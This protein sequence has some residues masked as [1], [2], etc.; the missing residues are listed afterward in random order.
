M[1]KFK[2]VVYVKKGEFGWVSTYIQDDQFIE[3]R[4][5]NKADMPKKEGYYEVI[6]D[7]GFR[8]YVGPTG[9][10]SIYG[11]G[12]CKFNK[13]DLVDETLADRIE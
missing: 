6:S 13:V 12:E 11:N 2:E 4:P 1:F 5:Q 7:K 9:K 8:K 3:V 10:T